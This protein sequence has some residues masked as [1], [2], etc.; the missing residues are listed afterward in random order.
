M[1]WYSLACILLVACTPQAVNQAPHNNPPAP[2]ATIPANPALPEIPTCKPDSLLLFGSQDGREIGLVN[3]TVE[4]RGT[5]YKITQATVYA[6]AESWYLNDVTFEFTRPGTGLMDFYRE[7]VPIN[8]KE[9]CFVA[10]LNLSITIKNITGTQ[11]TLQL[12]EGQNRGGLRL[13]TV[14]GDVDLSKWVR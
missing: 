1:K 5:Y 13:V 7:V 2:V 3:L 8:P 6:K 14:T 12:G 4:N 10:A 11:L 9:Q